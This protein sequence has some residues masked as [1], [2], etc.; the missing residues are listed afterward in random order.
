MQG[1]PIGRGL[2]Q[3]EASSPTQRPAPDAAPIP[4]TVIGGFLGAGKTTLLNHIFSAMHGVRAA[5]L[6]NDF[7]AINID[8]KLV[9][10]VT[11]DTIGLAN[12]CICCSIRED[13]LAACLDI[14][15]RSDPPEVLIIEASGVSDPVELIGTLDAMPL[16]PLLRIDGLIAVVDA[17]Q[18]PR[19]LNGEMAPLTRQQIAA[20]DL[21]V[22]NKCDLISAESR[23]AARALVGGVAPRCRI[24]ET[25]HARVPVDVLFGAGA[26]LNHRIVGKQAKPSHRQRHVPATSAADRG[27]ATWHWTS[28]LPLSLPKVKSTIEQLP[29]SVYRAK[30]ILF[31]EDLPRYQIALQVVGRRYNLRDTRNWGEDAA[32]SEIVVIGQGIDAMALQHAFNGCIGTGDESR[33]PTLRISRRIGEAPW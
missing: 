20:A 8:A 2:R 19:L 21:V 5:V 6:V 15:Q 14:V 27:L 26:A 33:S 29:E 25:S 4:V 22:L 16:H 12:G 7:G 23:Q 10:N 28:D 11:G 18:L 13:L 9:V 1:H 3:S 31:L 30:G 17:E 24:V 32:R